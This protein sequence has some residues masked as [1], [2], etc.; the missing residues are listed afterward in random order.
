MK[1]LKDLIN[2]FTSKEVATKK[3]VENLIFFVVML[4]LLVIGINYIWFNDSGSGDD[5]NFDNV[6]HITDDTV[7]EKAT[8]VYSDN[9]YN[10]NLDKRLESILSKVNG[11]S[12][13][14]VLITY[15][16]NTK[17]VP[18]YNIEDS[19][20]VT[21]ETDSDGGKRDITEKSYTKE[22]VYDEKSNTKTVIVETSINPTISGVIVVA[23]FGNDISI[24]Q[25]IISAVATVANISEYKVQ[26]LSGT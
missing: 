18:V 10:E 23:D 7:K 9:I 2:S 13:V 6:K 14:S 3:K 21:N 12:N 8:T 1:K 15:S 26:V 5:V 25:Q 17:I 20:T 22:V 11:V 16:N 4:I 19:E 24:K